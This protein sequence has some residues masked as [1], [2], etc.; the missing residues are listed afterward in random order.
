M[1]GHYLLLLNFACLEVAPGRSLLRRLYSLK[2]CMKKRLPNY[3]LCLSTGTKQDLH[4]WE[5]F[6]QSYN[7]ITMFGDSHMKTTKERGIYVTTLPHE[8]RVEKGVQFLS[9]TWPKALSSRTATPGASLFPLLVVAKACGD[10]LMDTRLVMEVADDDLVSLVNTQNH[11]N[12]EVMVVVRKW[13]GLLLKDNI[14]WVARRVLVNFNSPTSSFPY[15]QVLTP[16]GDQPDIMTH[17]L[18]SYVQ[19]WPWL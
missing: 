7:G 4:T 6:L 15:V 5:T 8:W 10:T 9:G 14:H 19:D 17:P 1:V 3:R 11:K 18:Q 12:K 2:K 13:V 16:D